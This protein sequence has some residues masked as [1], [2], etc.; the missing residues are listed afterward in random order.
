[1][2]NFAISNT[3]ISAN[4]ILTL[5]LQPTNPISAASYL[6]INPSILRLTY[7]YNNYNQGTQPSQNPTTDGTLLIGNLTGTGT[8]SSPGY[9]VLNNFTLT[10]PPYG[11]K[12][13][14]LTF[15]TS[16]LVGN[17]YYLIDS[18]SVSITATPST[19]TSGGISVTNTSLNAITTYNIWFI[20]VNTLV[21]SSF[22]IVSFPSTISLVG[23]TCSLANIN[24][25]CT[26]TNATAINIVLNTVVSGN[27]NISIT[28]SSVT[29]PVTTTPTSSISIVTYYND[30][31]SVVDMLTTGLIVTATPVQLKAATLTSSSYLVGQT[32]TYTLAI[33]MT[34][35]LPSNSA[36]TITIPP[37]SFPL[38][39]VTLN[40]FYI[41]TTLISGC[42]M[43]QSAPMVLKLA[44][45]CFTTASTYIK[46]VVNSLSN[47]LSTKP[48]DSWQI[49]TAYN[50]YEM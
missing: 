44:S 28:I 15:T 8:A 5:S 10:N 20:T 16:N 7:L 13:V 18:S 48:S 3:A 34:N 26:V 50:G 47:P 45:S 25:L 9:L 4:N 12:P 6:R 43:T 19:I 32:S 36:L 31:D 49:Q 17:T 33:N 1:M 21:V 46:L 2:A 39:T 30:I 22:I 37:T 35:T 29:N 42:A 23:S 14:T 24:S 40:A 38:S 41:G 27:T 11:N